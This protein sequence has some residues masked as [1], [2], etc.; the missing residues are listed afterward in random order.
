[1]IIHEETAPATEVRKMRHHEIPGQTAEQNIRLAAYF[2]YEDRLEQGVAGTAVDDWLRAEAEVLDRREAPV[3]E[4]AGLH[5]D[6]TAIKGIGKVLAERLR[7][8]G[9]SSLEK[10]ADWSE[11][12]VERLDAGLGL[13]GRI[14][15]DGWI[16]QARAL[17]GG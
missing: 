4:P 12:D 15:R 3:V 10:I 11:T 17:L 2:R 7:Q 14:E 13:R 5:H 16:R 1:M 9:C 8:A 6:L